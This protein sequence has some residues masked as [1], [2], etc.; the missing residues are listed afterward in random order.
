MIVM[1]WNEEKQHHSGS[2]GVDLE[3]PVLTSRRSCDVMHVR[4][5]L[6]LF[7]ELCEELNQEEGEEEDDVLSDRER[8][9][10]IGG[11]T[12]KLLGQPFTDC[13]R[14]ISTRLAEEAM[15]TKQRG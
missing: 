8:Q 1:S 3:G 7:V 6:T 9:W 5:Q 13:E 15:A 12:L 4:W 11:P 10:K 2:M 14:F